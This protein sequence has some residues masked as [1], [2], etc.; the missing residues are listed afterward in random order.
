MNENFLTIN[1]SC[2][3]I[4][5]HQFKSNIQS[6]T[7]V[8]SWM[9]VAACCSVISSTFASSLMESKSRQRRF[10]IPQINKDWR[11]TVKFTLKFPLEGLDT[12]FDGNVPFSFEFNPSK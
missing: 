3:D 2:I 4:Q 6:I 1:M 12:S 10:V 7:M 5:L 8:K 11:F 9:L